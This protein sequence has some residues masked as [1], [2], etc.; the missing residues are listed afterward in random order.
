MVSLRDALDAAGLA[1]T[2]IIVPD[3]GSCADVT[4]AAAANSSFASAV[5]ALGEHYP[6]KVR[7]G[8]REGGREG[9]SE[10]LPFTLDHIPTLLTSAH[11]QPLRKWA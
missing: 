10:A 11:A 5:Y 2:K 6:C 7:G 8:E 1:A 4:S 9:C 3:G